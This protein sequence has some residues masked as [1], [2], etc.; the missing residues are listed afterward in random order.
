MYVL[1]DF[2]SYI[3]KVLGNLGNCNTGVCGGLED[4][5]LVTGTILH[6]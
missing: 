3:S 2:F 5:S 4:S 6:Q 1:N